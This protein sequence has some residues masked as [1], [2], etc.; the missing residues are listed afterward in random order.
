MGVPLHDWNV[1]AK[2]AIAIQKSFRASLILDQA[3]TRINT[4]AGIDIS[5][6][7]KSSCLYA[8]V[9]VLDIRKKEGPAF[10]VIDKATAIYESEFPYI[11]GLLSFREIPAVLAAWKQLTVLPDCIICDGHGLAHPRRMGLACH[12][13]LVLDIPSIGCGKTRLIGHYE[14]PGPKRGDRSPLIDRDE[15]VGSVLRSR[16]GVAPLFISQG[17]K[18]TLD[19]AVEVILMSQSRYRLPEPIRITHHLANR[20]RQSKP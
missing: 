19:V 6:D 16:E 1:P 2:E 3:P 11:P 17:H 14:E 5:S 8:A 13:G 7:K 9:V 12:L 20:L 15:V 4:V 18:I 10:P